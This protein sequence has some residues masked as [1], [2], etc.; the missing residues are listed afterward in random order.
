VKKVFRHRT[1]WISMIAGGLIFSD[2]PQGIAAPVAG[3]DATAQTNR[4][5]SATSVAAT[6]NVATPTKKLIIDDPP[7][8]EPGVKRRAHFLASFGP[9]VV[10]LLIL[11]VGMGVLRALRQR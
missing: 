9:F 2:C 3:T 1:I 8:R 7:P 10:C 11:G 5:E 4:V 6:S